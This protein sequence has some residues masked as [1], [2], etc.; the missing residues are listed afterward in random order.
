M[1]LFT[2]LNKSIPFITDGKVKSVSVQPFDTEDV[3]L[4]MPGRHAKESNGGDFCVCVTDKN[5]GWNIH[6]FTHQDIFKDFENKTAENIELATDLH[7][8]Y[9]RIIQSNMGLPEKEM[10]FSTGMNTITL[11][12]ALVCLAVAEHRRY[13]Q[14]EE[15]FGG[16]YL[17][18]RYTSGI[19]EGKWTA[20]DCI[21]VQR[22]G[23]SGVQ[24][25]ERKFGL[26]DSTAA[27]LATKER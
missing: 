5:M 21:N 9:L 12:M 20:H 1:S 13:G 11:L 7:H 27:L 16:R 17:P 26:P 4:L 3:T 14:H 2:Q 15:N 25:L 22:F 8:V 23:R 18:W 6:Q 24:S 19:V 10:V